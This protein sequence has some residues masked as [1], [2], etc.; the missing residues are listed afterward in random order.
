MS[1]V[2]PTI[3]PTYGGGDWSIRVEE[4]IVRNVYNRDTRRL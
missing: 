3:S 2:V 1:S 4:T